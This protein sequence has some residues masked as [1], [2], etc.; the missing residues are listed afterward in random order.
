MNYF[1]MT[2]CKYQENCEAYRFL[3]EHSIIPRCSD[4]LDICGLEA[5]SEISE[6]CRLYN[7]FANPPEFT[8]LNKKPYLEKR[9]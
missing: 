9:L 1:F 5:P 3:V 4:L 8:P 6:S 7:E 2:E